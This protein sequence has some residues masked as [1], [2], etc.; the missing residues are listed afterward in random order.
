MGLVVIVVIHSTLPYYSTITTNQKEITVTNN[1]F[2]FVAHSILS[3][4]IQC[5]LKCTVWFVVV[6]GSVG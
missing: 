1:G 6:V 2:G 3:R 4:T 5:D